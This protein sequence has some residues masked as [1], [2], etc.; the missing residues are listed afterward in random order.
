MA[1]CKKAKVF[2]NTLAVA[3]GNITCLNRPAVAGL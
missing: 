2:F 3:A 1:G